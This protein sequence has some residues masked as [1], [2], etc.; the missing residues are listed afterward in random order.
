MFF[1]NNKQEHEEKQKKGRLA[2]MASDACY[3][4]IY[5][6]HAAWEEVIKKLIN[7]SFHL[8]IFNA[9]VL[10]ILWHSACLQHWQR[11]LPTNLSDI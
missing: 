5:C 3:A 8:S 11:P 2:L 9:K 1:G 7:L 10:R 6:T 4:R